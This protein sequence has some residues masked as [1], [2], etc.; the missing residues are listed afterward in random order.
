MLLL[1]RRLLEKKNKNSKTV[2]PATRPPLQ[3]I[4]LDPENEGDRL[5]TTLSEAKTHPSHHHNPSHT[6][7]KLTSCPTVSGIDRSIS[8][9]PYPTPSSQHSQRPSQTSQISDRIWNDHIIIS[10]SEYSDSYSEGEEEGLITGRNTSTF[11]T[12][13]HKPHHKS[14]INPESVNNKI[15]KAPVRRTP[16][17]PRTI[18]ISPQSLKVKRIETK[19]K[20]CTIWENIIEKYSRFDEENQGDVVNLE[21]FSIEENKGH[22][23]KLRNFDRSEIW[24]ELDVNDRSGNKRRPMYENLEKLDRYEDQYYQDDHHH[25]LYESSSH[26]TDRHDPICLLTPKLSRRT[27]V[28]NGNSGLLTQMKPK[29]QPGFDPIS[30]ITPPKSSKKGTLSESVSPS[31]EISSVFSSSVIS[32]SNSVT[33]NEDSFDNTKKSSTDPENP[34]IDTSYINHSS[35]KQQPGFIKSQNVMDFKKYHPVDIRSTSAT[36]GDTDPI[37]FLTPTKVHHR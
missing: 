29:L 26:D 1:K 17:I 25:D 3:L 2:I 10:D 16:V 20:F 18:S 19:K 14:I 5:D 37:N 33:C 34:F 6:P 31:S 11:T 4:Q 7:T 35:D 8:K 9:N 30:L 15:H 23:K 36:T 21:D 22:I 27:G 28:D 32:R 12:P 13:A 24:N